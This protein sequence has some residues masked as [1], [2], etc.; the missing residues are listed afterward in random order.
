VKIHLKIENGTLEGELTK[1]PDIE[2]VME[3]NILI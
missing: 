3:E 1:Y 2:I